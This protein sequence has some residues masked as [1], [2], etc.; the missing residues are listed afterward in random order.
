MLIVQK[1]EIDR[2]TH[3]IKR[4]IE[5]TRIENGRN[6]LKIKIEEKEEKCG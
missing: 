2:A 4:S 3:K 5:V 1:S 6:S